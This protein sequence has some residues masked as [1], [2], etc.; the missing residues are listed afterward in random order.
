M[1]YRIFKRGLDIAGSLS[2]LILAA[3]L[4]AILAI[5][6]RWRMGGPV[7][8]RH[9]RPGLNEQPFG[10]LKFRTM[11]NARDEN[12]DFLSDDLRLTALGLF[13]RRYSLDELPQFWNVLKGEMSLVG[14]R[15]LE[16]RY[17]SRYSASQRLRHQVKPGITGWVQINGRNA[18]SW[19]EKF[20]LDTW[21]VTHSGFWLDI[22]ILVVTA[23]KVFSADGISYAGHVTMPDFMGSLEPAA[24]E[25]SSDTN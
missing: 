9:D 3:P 12:G 10:C 19:D 17:L 16:M 14:P 18:L 4:M 8:F 22:K 5:A 13:L 23:W 6:I 11:T 24:I 25:P 1:A 21:Y 7:L 2:F 20:A 15:P